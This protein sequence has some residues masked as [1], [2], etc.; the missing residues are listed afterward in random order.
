MTISNNKI[1]NSNKNFENKYANCEIKSLDDL[2][3]INNSIKYDINE[4]KIIN[5]N[6]T[7]DTDNIS[8]DENDDEKSININ[9]KTAPNWAKDLNHNERKK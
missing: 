7:Y 9:N 8:D 5:K 2:K 4:F 6:D 1:N 3:N